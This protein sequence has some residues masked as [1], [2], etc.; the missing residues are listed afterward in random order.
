MPD[1]WLSPVLEFLGTTVWPIALLSSLFIF[2]KHIGR[3]ID[4]ISEITGFGTNAKRSAILMSQDL[5]AETSR[6]ADEEVSIDETAPAPDET[7]TSDKSS[8]ELLSFL[9]EQIESNLRWAQQNCTGASSAVRAEIIRST[10][11]DLRLAVR[12]V[13]YTLGGA[14]VVAGKSLKHSA[15]HV[16]LQRVSAPTELVEFLRRARTFSTQVRANELQVNEQA[17][18]NYIDSLIEINQSLFAWYEQV[19]A[20]ARTAK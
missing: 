16:I 3:F 1:D 10:Y 15:P 7:D 11:T 20:R 9:R 8:S 19:A 13:G 14:A 18:R 5:A 17:A 4:E 12:L 6:G 2:R